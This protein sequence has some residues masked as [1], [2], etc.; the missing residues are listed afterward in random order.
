MDII[1]KQNIKIES[2]LEKSTHKIEKNQTYF[3]IFT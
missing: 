2:I 3:D 1:N